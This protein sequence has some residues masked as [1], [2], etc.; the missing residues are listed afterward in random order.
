MKK[1]LKKKKIYMIQTVNILRRSLIGSRGCNWCRFNE[2]SC[3]ENFYLNNSKRSFSVS[4]SKLSD[5]KKIMESLAKH[6]ED[7]LNFKKKIDKKKEEEQKQ[8]QEKLSKLAEEKKL[9]QFEQDAAQELAKEKNSFSAQ[10]ENKIDELIDKHGV[11]EDKMISRLMKGYNIIGGK[12]SQEIFDKHA[13]EEAKIVGNIEKR[14]MDLEDKF[15]GEIKSV[16]YYREKVDIEASRFK[17]ITHLSRK[18]EVDVDNEVKKQANY[19]QF[20]EEYEKERSAW[21][22]QEKLDV[23]SC[24]DEKIIV[25]TVLESNLEKPS[26]MAA[27]LIEE[28]GP[29]Y[30]GGDDGGG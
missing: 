27:S 15:I 16:A 14:A 29:D 1:E 17:Q 26:E 5:I 12:K 9:Q 3:P 25:K 2:F 19:P 6:N 13:N 28:M 22:D 30:G 18:R 4:N 21:L 20:K 11:V 23:R 24:R 10:S 8:E 7:M